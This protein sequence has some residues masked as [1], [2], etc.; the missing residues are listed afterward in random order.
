MKKLAL[1][2]STT[3]AIQ[4]TSFGQ[5]DRSIQPKATAPATINIKDSEVFTL[6][7]GI[8]VILSENH[9]T[10]KVSVQ[11]I[12]GSSSIPEGKKTGLSSIA[13]ELLMSGTT[14]RT[15]DQLDREIDYIGAQLT[16]SS[17]HIGLDCLKKHLNKGIDLMTDVLYHPSFT[18]SEFNRIK[19]RKESDILSAKTEPNSMA[20]N[21]AARANFPTNHPFGEIETDETIKNITLED[22]KMFHKIVFTP[23]G[24]YLVFVGDITKEEALKI[25]NEQFKSWNGGEKIELNNGEGYFSDARRV[26]FVNKPNAVQS[27]INVT[28]PM[29]IKLGDKNQLAL[30]VLNN[31][32]GGGS[33]GTRLFQNLRE[34]HGYTYGC[35]S[36]A[37]ITQEG[38]YF[39]ASG[40]FRNEVTDSAITEILYELDKITKE[41]V[42]DE[43]LE[44]VKASMAGNFA[45]SLERPATLAEFAFRTIRYNLPS[46][47]YKDYLKSLNAI[48]KEQLL[49]IAKQYLN[50]ANCNIVVVGNESVIEKIKKFDADGAI[51]KL[52]A[53]GQPISERKTAN[54]T[55]N[56]LIENYILKITN[57]PNIKEAN[58]K[59]KKLTSLSQEFDLTCPQIPFPV[60]FSTIQK[61]PFNEYI[62]FELQGQTMGKSVFNGKSG[63]EESNGQK[64]NLSQTQIEEKNKTF[65]IIPEMS[66]LNNQSKTEL[67][68]IETLNGKEVFILR[69]KLNEA[70]RYHYYDVQSFL[71]VKTTKIEAE[72]EQTITYSDYKEID[73]YLFPQSI[74]YAIGGLNFEGKIN[75]ILINS[76]INDSMFN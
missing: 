64:K 53:L 76:K 40:S 8:K 30:S 58:K 70:E 68:G 4:A 59:I 52:D 46:N 44:N 7:N 15:K 20:T 47:Y 71:K 22:V 12:L 37:K 62:S 9:K 35:Y 31:I 65:G 13:G 57:T 29:K 1:A 39:V 17:E 74:S 55:Q 32:I 66:F 5:I 3:L 54:L 48:T 73:G 21:A 50:V 2:L 24:S 42:T 14:N 28:F 18:E 56:Q 60:K 38:S 33:F 72:G 34:K 69:E 6:E 23:K 10:P 36:K 67:L 61:L 27:T 25:A 16:T 63:F 19:K 26:L 49:A 75:S 41:F 51:E 43:E 45:R 11:L